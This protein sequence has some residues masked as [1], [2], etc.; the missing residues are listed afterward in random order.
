MKMR[1]GILGFLYRERRQCRYEEREVCKKET[2]DGRG[3]GGRA[4]GAF[5]WLR[6]PD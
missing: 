2:Y 6:V 1:C 5:K 4:S 3:P